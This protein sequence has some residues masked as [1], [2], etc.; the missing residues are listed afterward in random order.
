MKPTYAANDTEVDGIRK[1][2]QSRIGRDL[3][4]EEAR[5]IAGRITGFFSIL[6]EWALAETPSPANDTGKPTASNDEGVRHDR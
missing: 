1:V 4:E 5:Q 2:W 6:A 3:T